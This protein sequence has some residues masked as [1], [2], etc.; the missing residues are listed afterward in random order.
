MLIEYPKTDWKDA[1]ARHRS[2]YRQACSAVGS[3]L[4]DQV[5]R[6]AA[7]L[8]FTGHFAA[9]LFFAFLYLIIMA[10]Y[11]KDAQLA[12]Y[13]IPLVIIFPGIYRHFKTLSSLRYKQEKEVIRIYSELLSNPAG[14]LAA[15]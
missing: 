2:D 10:I 12:L 14:Q 13:V 9:A 3:A 11:T 4:Q 1:W 15:E 8:H 5:E 6:H 7:L